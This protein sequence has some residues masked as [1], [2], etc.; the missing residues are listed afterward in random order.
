MSNKDLLIG[1]VAAKT[2]LN[3]KTIRY[4]EEVG[5]IPKPRRR[6][7]G[8]ASAGYRRYSG[9]DAERLRLVKGARLLGLSLAEIRQLL[10]SLTSLNGR[11][12]RHRLDL[13]LGE[14]LAAIDT[15]MKDLQLLRDRLEH[16]KDVISQEKVEAQENCCDPL[17]GPDICPPPVV[18]IEV[19]QR[20][21]AKTKN[22]S[23]RR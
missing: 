8:Y 7:T 13:V 16:I 10:S 5:L 21:E 4:Y 12:D 9:Q 22:T 15:K 23:D 14:K 1:E 6:H 19:R 3:P 11:T 20:D 2:G 17:C 18:K